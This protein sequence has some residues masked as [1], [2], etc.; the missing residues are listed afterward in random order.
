MSPA[1]ILAACLLLSAPPAQA[2]AFAASLLAAQESPSQQSAAEP[3]PQSAKP[4]SSEPAK[5]VTPATPS[6]K[7][8][9]KKKATAPA[10][11][12]PP[13]KRVVRN[14][15]TDDPSVQLAPG[16]SRNQANRQQQTTNQLLAATE[17]NLKKISGRT[18]NPSQQGI[19]AQIHQ[20]MDQSKQAAGDGDPQRANNL[21][22]KAHLLSEDLAK[23]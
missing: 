6:S 8:P 3:T 12:S 23:H 4:E 10:S 11:T 19:V 13:T 17:V 18:L 5:A 1:A 9:H 20:Y 2:R 15:S 7:K 14:G 21:A 22:L 16:E